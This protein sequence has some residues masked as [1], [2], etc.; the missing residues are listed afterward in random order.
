MNATGFAL[1]F[2]G[3]L[4]VQHYIEPL[5]FWGVVLLFMAYMIIGVMADQIEHETRMAEFI[6]L[7]GRMQETL[8]A[9]GK[10]TNGE[11]DEI[12]DDSTYFDKKRS[13]TNEEKIDE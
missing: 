10:Y 4:L 2:V 6:E 5:L 8:D 13:Q 9:M 1:F 12:S 11:S 3:S 7:K